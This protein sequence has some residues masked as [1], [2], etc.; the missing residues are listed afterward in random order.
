MVVVDKQ[1]LVVVNTPNINSF[2]IGNISFVI[3][4]YVF[5]SLR[6]V[7]CFSFLCSTIRRSSL[8]VGRWQR[9]KEKDKQRATSD[10][11]IS[12]IQRVERDRFAIHFSGGLPPLTVPTN[13]PCQKPS[14]LRRG[15]L[16]SRRKDSIFVAI[17]PS[18]VPCRSRSIFHESSNPSIRSILPI[19]VPAHLHLR[20][21]V[22]YSSPSSCPFHSPGTS[23][24]PLPVS[25]FV[26]IQPFSR[27][28]PQPMRPLFYDGP[29]PHRSCFHTIA[30][31]MR[32]PQSLLPLS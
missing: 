12:S 23:R 13:R 16:L 24:I 1:F 18:F 3:A 27:R 20:A 26:P 19:I 6:L 10:T 30:R 9:M 29:D 7:I 14:P 4:L 31:R 8:S 11:I 17:F 25:I 15:E 28:G 22:P 32:L 21:P 5:D 2:D